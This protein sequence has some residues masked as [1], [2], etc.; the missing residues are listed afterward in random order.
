ML[1]CFSDGAW[2]SLGCPLG[3]GG[4][5]LGSLPASGCSHVWV[6]P[7]LIMEYYEFSGSKSPRLIVGAIS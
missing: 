6:R 7:P 4:F 1:G 2:T 3:D 5:G